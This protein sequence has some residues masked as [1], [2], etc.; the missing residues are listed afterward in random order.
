MS[1][2]IPL[3]TGA[4]IYSTLKEKSISFY[5]PVDQRCGDQC[6]GCKMTLRTSSSSL[7]F[8]YSRDFKVEAWLPFI[9]SEFTNR[10]KT[11][12]KRKIPLVKSYSHCKCNLQMFVL[13]PYSVKNICRQTGFP[14]ISLI[15]FLSKLQEFLGSTLQIFYVHSDFDMKQLWWEHLGS[16]LPKAAGYMY[17]HCNLISGTCQ[18]CFL[19]LL[20]KCYTKFSQLS[21]Y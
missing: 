5:S 1:T 15:N 8:L 9:C 16:T 18:T 14:F 10:W 19:H 2:L 7:N 4:H 21:I 3:R 6:C 11:Y 17:S 20:F 12:W 13:V